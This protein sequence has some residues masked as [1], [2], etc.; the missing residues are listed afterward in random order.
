MHQEQFA[1]WQ[2]LQKN[3]NFNLSFYRTSVVDLDFL[4]NKRPL[5]QGLC[6]NDGLGAEGAAL[7]EQAS[8]W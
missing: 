3:P 4:L 8:E 7:P 6:A 2:Q 1:L 5:L